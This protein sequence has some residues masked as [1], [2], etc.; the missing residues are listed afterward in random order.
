[1]AEE[2]ETGP[3]ADDSSIKKP[4]FFWTPIDSLNPYEKNPRLH[5]EDDIRLIMHSLA[6]YGWTNPIQIQKGTGLVISGHG[7]L[8]AA[9]R[10]GLKQV[11][12]V[13]LE[14]NDT[15]SRA[16]RIAD[17]AIAE[18]SQWHPQFLKEEAVE[19]D[20][21]GFNTGLMGL[22]DEVLE[23][24]ML[25]TGMGGNPGLTDPDAI[26]E[27][28]AKPITELGDL[29]ELGDHRLLCGD[30]TTAAAM[31]MVTGGVPVDLLVTDPPYGVSAG[32]GRTQTVKALNIKPIENDELRGGQLEGFI[33][34][35]LGHV[36]LKAGGSFY[37]FYDQKTQHEFTGAIRKLG[38]KQRNTL[39]WNKN[40]FGLS[41]HKGYRPKYELIAFGHTGDDYEWHGGN[42]QADVW[43]HAR[44]Q[45]RP[46]NHPTPKPVEVVER[47]IVNS[48]APGE[49]VLDVFGGVGATLIACERAGRKCRMVE[50]EPAYVDVIVQRWEEFTG[51]KARRVSEAA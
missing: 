13:A 35:A 51:K 34:E 45:D 9:K 2:N 3:R 39:I 29:W 36:P 32:G 11:P 7:R 20:A 23:G 24:M 28:P 16:Y 40:F 49:T 18:L 47:A 5:T 44:P 41:G 50:L 15:D 43:D 1:M 8:E 10:L 26:P 48:S 25:R 4:L 27:V 42:D 19:L 17:N 33:F 22:S 31:Q 14:H 46:G 6:Y 37:V 21:F 38:W 12:V 30:S